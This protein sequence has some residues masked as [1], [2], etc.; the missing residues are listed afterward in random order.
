MKILGFNEKLVPLIL[1][2]EKTITWRLFRHHDYLKVNDI[3]LLENTQTKEIFGK[4]KITHI[5]D[6]IMKEISNADKEGHEEFSNEKEM[7]VW[8]SECYGCRVDENTP[9]KIVRFKIL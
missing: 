1:K 2:G 4:A 6:K 9:V 8:Y 7:Y 5:K 3:I